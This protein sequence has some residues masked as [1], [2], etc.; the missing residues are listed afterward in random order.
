[1]N[2]AQKQE[3]VVQLKQ[4]FDTAKAIFSADYR[5]LTVE[6]IT[7][8]RFELK[9]VGT[10]FKV[11]KNRIALRALEGR[12]LPEFRKQFDYMTGIAI[13]H[14]DP[15][16]GAK[17]LTSFAKTNDKLKLKGALVEGR[18]CSLN[19][20]KALAQLPSKPELLAKLLGTLVAV[21]T[22]FVRVLN[23]VPAN[24][25]YVLEAIRKQKADKGG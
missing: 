22:G 24:W 25:V 17:A 12:E 2:R 5:G 9:K 13:T 20:I 6:D 4:T 10:D 19:D 23:G 21:P 15:S 18:E 14:D 3:S 1:V 11:V 7:K 16:A 8:L